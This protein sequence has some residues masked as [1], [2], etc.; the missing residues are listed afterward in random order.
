MRGKVA[1]LLNRELGISMAEIARNAGVCPAAVIKA[2]LPKLQGIF[3]SLKSAPV[4]RKRGL[5]RSYTV[6]VEIT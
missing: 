2:S 4:D 6:K 1:Y 3:K 5:L